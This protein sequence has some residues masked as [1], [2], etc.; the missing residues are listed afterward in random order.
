MKNILVAVSIA[1]MSLT[2]FGAPLM[3]S[4]S[5]YVKIEKKKKKAKK[6]GKHRKHVKC[7]AFN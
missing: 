7:D 2:T 6:K 1:G 3:K 4:E 5:A